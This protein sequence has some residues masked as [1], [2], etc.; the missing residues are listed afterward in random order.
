VL[1][2]ADG[3]LGRSYGIQAIPAQA[4]VDSEGGL[5]L[6]H[7]GAVTEDEMWATVRALPP[8]A[9]HS[10]SDTLGNRYEAAISNLAALGIIS[11]YPDG[12]FRPSKPVL[13]Q[14]L[15]K[16]LVK[17]LDLP[18]TGTESCAFVDVSKKAD[19]SDPNY[20]EKYVAVCVAHGIVKGKTST[21]F[22][23]YDNVSRQ[24]FLTMVARA[25]RLPDPPADYTPRFTPGQFDPYEHYQNA[26]RAAYAGLLEGLW[27]LGPACDF[28]GAL[29]RGECAQVLSLR[30][31]CEVGLRGLDSNLGAALRWNLRGE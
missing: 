23:P 15:A 31:S 25:A 12:T 2:D 10:F 8:V 24:Q 5:A 16:M 20:P 1:L 30:P 17:T 3:A 28:F 22:A 19:P 27:D 13:R 6:V 9:V 4:F 29:T 21:E 26:R 11:G 18:V 7:T 14:Q